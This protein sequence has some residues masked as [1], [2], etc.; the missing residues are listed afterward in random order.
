MNR[1]VD[2][3]HR[4]LKENLKEKTSTSMLKSVLCFNDTVRG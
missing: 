1:L 2:I 4:S 3:F